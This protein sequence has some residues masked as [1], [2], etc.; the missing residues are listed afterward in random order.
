MA[1][2]ELQFQRRQPARVTDAICDKRDRVELPALLA[3]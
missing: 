2:L 1:M 3:F